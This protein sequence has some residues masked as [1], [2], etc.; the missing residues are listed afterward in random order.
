MQWFLKS[1]NL[2]E[3]YKHVMNEWHLYINLNLVYWETED[4]TCNSFSSYPHGGTW[5]H[6]ILTVGMEY[7]KNTFISYI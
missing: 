5:Y 4:N 1:G 2:V 6:V 3:A 7:Y